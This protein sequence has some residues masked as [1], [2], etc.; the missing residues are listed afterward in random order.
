M[1]RVVK[2]QTLCISRTAPSSAGSRHQATRKAS[3]RL[4][5]CT[6]R[7]GPNR[8]RKENGVWKKTGIERSLTGSAMVLKSPSAPTSSHWFIPNP[9]G[10]VSS[11]IPRWKQR[12]RRRCCSS[13][14]LPFEAC[15]APS[16]SFTPPVRARRV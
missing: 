11:K 2:V 5:N 10:I 1:I 4:P 15:P 6:D 7:P 8:R 13:P 3:G 16:I 9:A 14:P 12:W